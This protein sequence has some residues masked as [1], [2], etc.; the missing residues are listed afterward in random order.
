M[1]KTYTIKAD[2]PEDVKRLA[3]LEHLLR[4]AIQAALKHVGGGRLVEITEGVSNG[5]RVLY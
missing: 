3:R 1:V 5:R 4:V 2:M